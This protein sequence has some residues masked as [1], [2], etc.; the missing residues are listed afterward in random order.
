MKRTVTI[1]LIALAVVA[2]AWANASAGN[3]IEDLTLED[4]HGQKIP[5]AWRDGLYTGIF[6]SLMSSKAVSCPMMSA[7]M[8]IAGVEAALSAKEIT[9]DWR[10]YPS[11]LYVLI[12]AGCKPA[13]TTEKS[14][15]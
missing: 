10:V 12:R 8:M 2:F 13:P 11:V 5:K 6:L 15:A 3:Y 4:L 9:A 7:N 14:N 1:L